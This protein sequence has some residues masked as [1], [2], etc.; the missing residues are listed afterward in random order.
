MNSRTL[1]LVLFFGLTVVLT[2]ASAFA[3]GGSFR[4]ANA[5]YSFDL[6]EA[7]WKMTAKPSATNPNVEYIYGDRQDGLLEIRKLTVGKNDTMSDLIQD[8]EQ[9][10]QFR[11]GF[12]AGKQETF[13]GRLKG[14]AYNFEYV[15]SGRNMSGRFY[16]LRANDNTVY[17]L[18]FTG[19]KDSLRSLRNQTDSI[20]RT[21]ALK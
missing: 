9:K 14:V 1:S 19:Q 13:S 10:L 11:S 2:A 7:A 15:S 16:F 17:L 12:V 20:A 3:Q 21:F 5:E 8:E 4:D 6:P 18:R